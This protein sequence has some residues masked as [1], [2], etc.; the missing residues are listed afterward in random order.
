MTTKS[1][2]LP[3][4]ALAAVAIAAACKDYPTRP[5]QPGAQ[6]GGFQ[7]IPCAAG[8]HCE[9]PAGECQGADLSG[10]CVVTPELCTQE[11]N[12]VCGCDGVTYGND[13]TRLAARVQKS[14]DGECAA[15]L[16]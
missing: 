10:T 11:Y 13:C 16:E 12:P 8:Q 3:A 4:L 1:L 5:D 7:G 15:A 2:C 6:C 9:L 14:H